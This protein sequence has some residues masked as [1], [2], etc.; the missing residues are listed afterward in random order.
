[1]TLNTK[2][3]KC[4]FKS[5]YN[6]LIR[7][8]TLWIADILF[9]TARVGCNDYVECTYYVDLSML[10]VARS[11]VHDVIPDPPKKIGEV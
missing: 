7:T 3:E 2:K 11:T 1:M 6:S 8:R 4:R 5:G 9:W 10:N